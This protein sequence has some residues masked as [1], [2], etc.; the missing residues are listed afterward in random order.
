MSGLGWLAGWMPSQVRVQSARNFGRVPD[1]NHFDLKNFFMERIGLE[2]EGFTPHIKE[3]IIHDS[4]ALFS[5]FFPFFLSSL[6][7]SFAVD[8]GLWLVK[9]WSIN[10]F[11]FILCVL[12]LSG[13]IW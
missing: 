5:S 3:G 6:F 7:F 4:S 13:S 1:E 11:G 8:G 10:G 2:V 9:M 12:F